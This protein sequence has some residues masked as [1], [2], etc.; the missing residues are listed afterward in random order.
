MARNPE[1]KS[2]LLASL[3]DRECRDLRYHWSFWARPAQMLPDG[4][5]SVWAI[6]AGRGF[7]KTRTGAETVREWAETLPGCRIA[8]VGRTAADV[9]DVMIRG[10][11]GILQ[12]SHP[13]FRPRYEPSKRLLTWPN[14]SMATA[15]SADEPD[16][17]RGPEHHK[18]WADEMAAWRF[19]DESWMHLEMGLRARNNPDHG[20]F[21]EPQVI[22]TTTPRPLPLLRE[23]L[24]KADTATTR[25]NTFDNRANLA[26]VYLRKMA[27]AYLDTRI[28]RQELFGELFEDVEG[29]LWNAQ[30]IEKQRWK[31]GGRGTREFP[32]MARVVVA[33]DPAFVQG[34]DRDET[35][36]VVCGRTP[37]RR[38][39]VLGD[40][41]SDGSPE[42]W[43]QRTLEA[44]DHFQADALVVETNRGGD[45]VI[46]MIR[47]AC[48]GGWLGLDG[49]KVAPRSCPRIIPVRAARGQS[50]DVR[51]EPILAMYER[52]RIW[53]AGSFPLLEDQMCTWVPGQTRK[54][55]D[56]MDAMVYGFT[57]LF[58]ADPA[59]VRAHRHKPEGW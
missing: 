37:D 56:R 25:G 53:H 35:G 24:A 30:L 32:Q 22:V 3:T 14:G 16:N 4:A 38:G 12:V 15:Y 26:P 20:W 28:G 41:S 29:A 33:V 6:I 54:S 27:D 10:K 5:W 19:A 40:W 42:Q 48:Q 51:A 55:P 39:F 13:D 23:I 44:Y 18:A 50:K 7:G 31:L 49:K 34:P 52:G 2:R 36:I 47:Q 8:L 43:A 58:P 9:R 17:L 57:E 21:T 45:L 11:A 1:A 59:G 46:Q